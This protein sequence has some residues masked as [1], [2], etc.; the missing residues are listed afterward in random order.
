[1]LTILL[2]SF[3]YLSVY[4]FLTI[5]HIFFTDLWKLFDHIKDTNELDKPDVDKL[6]QTYEL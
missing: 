3:S 5:Y 1:M 2:W 6:I 4:I